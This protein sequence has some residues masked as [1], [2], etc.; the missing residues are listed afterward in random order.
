[1]QRL[2]IQCS[3]IHAFIII[4][5]NVYTIILLFTTHTR[6]I[7]FVLEIIKSVHLAG[8]MFDDVSLLTDTQAFE[9]V[10]GDADFLVDVA[11]EEASGVHVEPGLVVIP[12]SLMIL[13]INWQALY[14]WSFG[15][16]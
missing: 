1:M 8:S 4:F 14:L 6:V 10:E 3:K 9:I 7:E 2:R 11:R 12:V 15:H 16:L 5:T 13:F